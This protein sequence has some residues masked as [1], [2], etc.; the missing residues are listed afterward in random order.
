MLLA[1]DF[2]AGAPALAAADAGAVK[3]AAAV[4]TSVGIGAAV[5]LFTVGT[6][7]DGVGVGMAVVA[8]AAAGAGVGSALTDTGGTG[9]LEAVPK[10]M[11]SNRSISALCGADIA[12][13]PALVPGRLCEEGS[14][15]NTPLLWPL[16]RVGETPPVSI[17]TSRKGYPAVASVQRQNTTLTCNIPDAS[18]QLAKEVLELEQV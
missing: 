2:G 14:L 6:A 16:L 3:A 15:L 8:G 1:R 12:L 17:T 10:S 7:V 9:A 18:V 13:P 4:D 11:S 5:D